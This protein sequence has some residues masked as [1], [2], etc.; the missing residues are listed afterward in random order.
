MV[1]IKEDKINLSAF[2]DLLF[3]IHDNTNQPL[4]QANQQYPA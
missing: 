3:I 2:L 1:F 4:Y